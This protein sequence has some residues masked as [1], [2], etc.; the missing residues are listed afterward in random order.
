MFQSALTG[1][2][3]RNS[4]E[5]PVD[6]YGM[7]GAPPALSLAWPVSPRL[8]PSRGVTRSRWRVQ[9]TLTT[10]S[11][12]KRS[13]RRSRS[14][15]STV[16]KLMLLRLV[17]PRRPSSRASRNV[18]M[19]WSSRFFQAALSLSTTAAFEDDFDDEDLE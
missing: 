17:S 16:R 5:D 6:E 4:M 12:A 2:F 7:D 11:L 18:V 1:G 14:T 9:G 19:I 15:S 13:P 3:M 10:R 8:P